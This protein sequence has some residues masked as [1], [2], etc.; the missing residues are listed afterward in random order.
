MKVCSTKKQLSCLRDAEGFVITTLSDK[1]KALGKL[2]FA[3]CF[4]K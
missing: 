4:S 2:T 3:K 1:E